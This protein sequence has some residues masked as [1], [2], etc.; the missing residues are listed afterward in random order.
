[1]KKKHLLLGMLLV[2]CLGIFAQDIIINKAGK[3]FDGFISREDS[4]AVYFNYYRGDAKIDTFIVRNDLSNYQY[5]ATCEGDIPNMDA[6]FAIDGGLLMSG[7][8]FAG[9]DLEYLFS[10]RFGIQIGGGGLGASAGINFH[11][12]PTIRS[13]YF[14]LQ[15]IVQ[16]IGSDKNWGYQKTIIGPMIVFRGR[17]WLTGQ[18][19]AG[20]ILDK[21]PAFNDYIKD[22][23]VA[24]TFGIGAYFPVK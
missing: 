1:M 4:S 7:S 21:G 12:L 9:V 3:R 2:N 16:G 5:N 17:H 8:T 22:V 15:Y 18:I 24:L 14:S 20:Y 10:N 6:N 13:S 11:F 23:P 19:G